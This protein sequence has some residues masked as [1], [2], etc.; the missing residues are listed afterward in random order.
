MIKFLIASI[1]FIS[2]NGGDVVSYNSVLGI[3]LRETTLKDV[4]AMYPQAEY[5]KYWEKGEW[6]MIGN[7]VKKI[8]IEEKGI[9]LFLRK[10]RRFGKY[11]VCTIILDSNFEGTLDC[12][13]GIN[14]NYAE[15]DAIFGENRIM[16]VNS[17]T[18]ELFYSSGNESITFICSNKF[19]NTSTFK[20]ESIILNA[21]SF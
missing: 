7:Y 13:I 4:R 16:S 12:G 8:I 14:S 18:A 6:I 2:L 21:S 10:K 19:A 1:I 15:I 3:E 17:K 20:V 9:T 5:S 11:K